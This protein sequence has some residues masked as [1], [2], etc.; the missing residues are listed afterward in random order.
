[1]SY[2]HNNNI[3]YIYNYELKAGFSFRY[4]DFY[5]PKY[6]LLIEYD[7][8]WWHPNNSNNP[9]DKYKNT[10]AIS[11]GFNLVRIREKTANLHWD[12][13]VWNGIKIQK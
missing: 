11:Q 3:D 8:A 9:A 13:I 1:M 2:F 6:N 10:L 4:Y 12:F 7:G 5:L